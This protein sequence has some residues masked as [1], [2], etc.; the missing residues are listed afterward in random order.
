MA[1]ALRHVG[2]EDRLSLVEHLTE[3]RVR[4]VVCL[5]AFVAATGVCMW[6]NHTV[7]K[8]LNHPL[9]QTVDHGNKDPLVQSARYDQALRQVLL[10]QVALSR[11]LA[12]SEDDPVTRKA[13]DQ[14]AAS[15]QRAAA[16]APE[17]RARRPVT[18]GVGEPFMETLK[19]AAYAGLL[20]A[21]PLILYQI[22]A[23]VLPAFSP[24]ERQIA[25]PAMLGVPFLFIGGVVFGYFMVLPP[26]IRFLQNFNTDSFDVLIQAQPYYKFV[27][28]LLVAMG[29]LFQIPIGILA[30]TR[31]GIVTTRQLRKNRRYAILVIAVIAM[32]LPGQDP[33][34]MTM[35]M[36][37]MYVL[38]EGSILLSWLMDR[39][40][41]RR[42][43]AE[44]ESD[45]DDEDLTSREPEYATLDQD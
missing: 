11:Q 19:V 42:A 10:N 21:L 37:P 8:I 32:L 33:V 16:L 25:V 3:L 4:I 22:Y 18:L 29:L 27:V 36:V 7:L 15:S 23:F 38:F 1:T 12:L 24:R 40:D 30:L 20:L 5:V 9:D 41:R 43:V 14:L 35:M 39:R 28:M 13:L 2:H 26:A 44:E 6:Q 31:V 45:D 17:V 34:T